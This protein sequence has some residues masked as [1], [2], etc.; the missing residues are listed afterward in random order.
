MEINFEYLGIAI[1]ALVAGVLQLAKV[2]G[3][4]VRL[5]PYVNIVLSVVGSMIFL[6]PGEIKKGVFV[7]ILIALTST[8]MYQ[9]TKSTAN[10]VREYRD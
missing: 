8:G 1:P 5:V 10:A 6:Y 4:P 9:I 3:L 7:G 2:A